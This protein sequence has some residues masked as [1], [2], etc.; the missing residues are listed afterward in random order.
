MAVLSGLLSG[1]ALFGTATAA[2]QLA[3]GSASGVVAGQCA[4]QSCQIANLAGITGQLPTIVPKG[5]S[6]VTTLE[7]STCSSNN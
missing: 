1:I 6:Y 7:E 3:F 2:P 4:G 5:G